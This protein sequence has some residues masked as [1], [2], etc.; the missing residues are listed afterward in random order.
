MAREKPLKT[1]EGIATVKEIASI[2]CK[3]LEGRFL[4][5][6]IGNDDRPAEPEHI[7]SA[8]EEINKILDDYQINAVAWV[9]HHLVEIRII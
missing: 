2:K 9:T 5:I 1:E 7:A 8:Q 3:E 4:H 6:K